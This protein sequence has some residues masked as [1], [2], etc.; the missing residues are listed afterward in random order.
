METIYAYYE[1]KAHQNY[2][3]SVA[4]ISR[5]KELVHKAD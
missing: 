4:K 2:E 1:M 3:N 5:L